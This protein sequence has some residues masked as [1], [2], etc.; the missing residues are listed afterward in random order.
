MSRS[1]R[2]PPKHITDHKRCPWCGRRNA[3]RIHEWAYKN[4]YDG[5]GGAQYPRGP[6]PPGKFFG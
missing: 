6:V 4:W 1:W 5:M 3:C 2:E